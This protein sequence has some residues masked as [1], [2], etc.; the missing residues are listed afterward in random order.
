ME[1]AEIYPFL[2][3]KKRQITNAWCFL[4]ADY[5]LQKENFFI[6]VQAIAVM[7]TM[8]FSSPLK[9]AYIFIELI[10]ESFRF[11]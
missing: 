10:L 3:N 2:K 1:M 11:K 4:K 9:G 5:Y 8:V 6:L 7:G